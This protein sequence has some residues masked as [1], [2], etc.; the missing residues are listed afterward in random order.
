VT[1]DRDATTTET[2]KAAE[3]I[4]VPADIRRDGLTTPYKGGYWSSKN[5]LKPKDNPYLRHP[6]RGAWLRGFGDAARGAAGQAAPAKGV[7]QAEPADFDKQVVGDSD[8]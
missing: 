1:P 7:E 3:R 6:D 2:S 8:G 5:G 4:P